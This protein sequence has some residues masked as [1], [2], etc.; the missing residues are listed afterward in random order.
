MDIRL[1]LDPCEPDDGNKVS[2]TAEPFPESCPSEAA[3]DASATASSPTGFCW[4]STPCCV[5]LALPFTFGEYG[6][7]PNTV[8]AT[9]YASSLAVEEA[10]DHAVDMIGQGMDLLYTMLDCLQADWSKIGQAMNM[11]TRARA[12]LLE[13]RDEQRWISYLAQSQTNPT[14]M[15]HAPPANHSG[16]TFVEEHG[17][18]I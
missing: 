10:Y 4:P 11:F 12:A 15:E 13:M 6:A 7:S 16:G 17:I 14:V 3:L 8:Q 1:I 18:N 5:D 2:A 9:V